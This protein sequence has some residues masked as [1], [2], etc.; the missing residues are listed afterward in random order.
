MSTEIQQSRQQ[1]EN[2]SRSLE[3]KVSD[4][5]QKLQQEVQ[6][7]AAAETALQ[8]ANQELQRLA[9]LDGL[10]QIAN[11][12]QFDLRLEQE[13]RRMK[14]ERLSLALI[15]CDVDYFKSY[16]DTY[17]HQ[18]GDDCLRS[19]A[20]VIDQGARRPSD[21]V[22]RYGGEEFAILLSNTD[23]AGAIEVANSIKNQIQQLQL[24]HQESPVSL[25]VTASFGVAAVSP[26][27]EGTPEELIAQA[28]RALYRA[29]EEGRDRVG[30]AG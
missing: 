26:S 4:R 3:E 29:K 27:E 14:R 25:C 8:S 11:R 10:T 6:R 30:E 23:L 16:N 28:D 21:L 1:L 18:M 9:F 17:G 24:P 22:A 5:T 15:L 7:R 12:R 2:Y 13:W 19:I 20:H